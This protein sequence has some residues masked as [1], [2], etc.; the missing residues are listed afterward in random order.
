MT[1]SR[2]REIADSVSALQDVVE[3]IRRAENDGL[4]MRLVGSFAVY[5]Y[6]VLFHLPTDRPETPKDIDLIGL[7]CE[8]KRIQDFM[9]S[10]GY[11]LD[12]RLLL[13]T[14]GRETYQRDSAI[15][16]IDIFFDR[17]DGSHPITLKTHLLRPGPAVSPEDLLLT[18]LQRHYLR[19]V[20]TW[21]C[22]TLLRMVQKDTSLDFYRA[23][24]GDSWG[25]YTTVLDN[26]GV[27]TP[28]CLETGQTIQRLIMEAVRTKK[29]WRW[30][31]RSLLGRRLKWWNEVYD[32]EGER[33][34]Q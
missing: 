19:P 13:L 9:L 32:V 28:D 34:R 25:L 30:K 15:S 8:R 3:L 10:A 12:A 31:L 24:M 7:R 6:A 11:H 17:V 26:L 4:H 29:S 5:F 33:Q 16:T 14:E 27:I 2:L 23:C 20:D 1:Q 22:C 21:D 18:K